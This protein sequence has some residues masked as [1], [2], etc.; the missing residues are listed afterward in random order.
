MDPH[1]VC[2]AEELLSGPY[3]IIVQGI[4]LP[5]GEQNFA[6][7]FEI[8]IKFCSILNLKTPTLLRKL[9]ELVKLNELKII[10]ST[11]KSSVNLVNRTL[12]EATED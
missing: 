8:F 2:V 12:L 11:N 5:C 7:S 3:Y 10:S 1:K 9:F 6:T 4:A